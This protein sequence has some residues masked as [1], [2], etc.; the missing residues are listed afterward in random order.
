MGHRVQIKGLPHYNSMTPSA[1][2]LLQLNSSGEHSETRRSELERRRLTTVTGECSYSLKDM[3]LH[4]F[5]LLVSSNA[6]SAFLP[7]VIM[8]CSL[9]QECFCSVS[10]PIYGHFQLQENEIIQYIVLSDHKKG[11]HYYQS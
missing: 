9:E 5:C 3:I 2:I 4:H 6:L 7:W 11:N 8:Y 1:K 10:D